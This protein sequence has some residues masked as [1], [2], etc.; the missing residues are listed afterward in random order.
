MN[1][2]LFTFGLGGLT[3]A[4]QLPTAAAGQPTGQSPIPNPNALTLANP[5]ISRFRPLRRILVYDDFDKGINGWAELQS[6]HNG[7]LDELR[8]ATKD[9]RPAQLSTCTFFDT[10]THGSMNG[11][12]S[13][14]VATK[15]QPFHTA[16]VLKRLTYSRSCR[17]Q[18]EMWFTY[19]AEQTFSESG[20]WD[21]NVNPSEQN[22]GDFTLNTDICA[23][24]GGPRYMLDLRYANTDT[25]GK[26]TQKWMYNT[27]L[28]PTSKMQLEGRKATQYVDYHVVN[29]SDWRD[30]PGGYQPLCF[31]ESA[32]KV[33]WHYLRWVFDLKAHKHEELQVNELTM[34][35]RNI[36]VQTYDQKYFALNHMLNIAMSVRTYKPIRNFLFVDSILISEDV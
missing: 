15:P 24:V 26:V 28:E 12:Y 25:E 29:A 11:T 17:V 34:D 32:T 3:A 8:P 21:G 1:R 22:F 33:N 4:S 13:L 6:N 7:N 31:N 30:I 23:G 10:G 16:A 18:F 20:H 2:R 19:K 9:M 36:P 5:E 35:L 27:S 14:K